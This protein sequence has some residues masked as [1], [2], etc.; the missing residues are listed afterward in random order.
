MR[1]FVCAAVVTV[2]AVSIALADEFGARI[3]DIKD[4]KVTFKKTEKGKVVGEEMTL[5]LT[6]DAT[7]AK[8]KISKGDDGKVKIEAGD[9]LDKAAV[10]ALMAKA[11]ESKAKSAGA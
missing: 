1:K 5:P 9:A 2:C 7:F 10:T 6:K 4:G 8:G 11:Q 3:M